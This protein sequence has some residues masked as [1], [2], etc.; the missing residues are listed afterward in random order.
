MIITSYLKLWNDVTRDNG[1]VELFVSEASYFFF[2]VSSS[3]MS[4]ESWFVD[5]S[6]IKVEVV[7]VNKENILRESFGI[8]FR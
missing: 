8:F 3:E 2:A 4:G 5:E 7:S 1:A 6:T